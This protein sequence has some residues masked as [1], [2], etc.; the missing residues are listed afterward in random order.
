MLSR[1]LMLRF[2]THKMKLLPVEG[3][4]CCLVLLGLAELA[5]NIA[6]F[7]CEVC[8]LGRA[9]FWIFKTRPAAC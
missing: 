2:N 8:H 9:R 5:L 1:A 7:E 6:I 4:K 3:P